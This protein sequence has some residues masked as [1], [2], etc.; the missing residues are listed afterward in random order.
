[1]SIQSMGV[2]EQIQLQASNI[3]ATGKSLSIPDTKGHEPVSFSNLLINSLNTIDQLR[4]HSKN[5]SENYVAG[6]PGIGLNDV[7]VSMQKSSIALNLGIQVRNKLVTAYQEVMNM[8][9]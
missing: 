5:M 7:M 8:P 6:M 9:V 3:A 4:T 2:L 1:M